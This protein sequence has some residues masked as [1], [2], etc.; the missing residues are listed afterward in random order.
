MRLYGD[1]NKINISSTC[2]QKKMLHT[3]NA[4]L[5]QHKQDGH[6]LDIWTE[7]DAAHILKFEHF[8]LSVLKEYVG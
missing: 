2:E 7:K 5:W 8:S 4:S 1:T 6:Q 3:V